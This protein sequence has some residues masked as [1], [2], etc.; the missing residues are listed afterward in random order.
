V[1]LHSWLVVGALVL[2]AVAHGAEP[3]GVAGQLLVASEQ[4]GDPRFQRTVIYMVSHDATGA[5]GLIVN[6]PV[7]R[8]EAADLLK[9]LGRE[10]R[11]ASGSIRV[12]YGGPVATG[13][14]LVLHTEEW[15]TKDTRVVSGSIAFTASPLVV[16]AIAHGAGP[17]RSLFALGHAGWAP[18]QL[19]AELAAD[20]W[21][22]VTADEALVFDDEATTKWDRAM[23]RRKISL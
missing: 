2:A 19:E 17:R 11:G 12:H 13:Q 21:I 23:A 5:L 4:M 8:V 20:A 14:G 15:R 1:A 7:A 18:H 10:N 22:T 6:R 9:D 16:D 3:V